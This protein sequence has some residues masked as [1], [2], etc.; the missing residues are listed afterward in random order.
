[1]K[2]IEQPIHLSLSPVEVLVVILWSPRTLA[3]S[4]RSP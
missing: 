1:M 2:C 3:E 4:S